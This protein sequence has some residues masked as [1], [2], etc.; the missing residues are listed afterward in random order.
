MRFVEAEACGLG[1]IAVHDTPSSHLHNSHHQ[2]RSPVDL[3]WPTVCPVMSQDPNEK[4]AA[5]ESRKAPRDFW[6]R[7][8]F[9]RVHRPI[10]AQDSTVASTKE[11][12]TGSFLGH[13]WSLIP[14]MSFARASDAQEIRQPLLDLGLSKTDHTFKFQ[15]ELPPSLTIPLWVFVMGYL[16]STFKRAPFTGQ[17]LYRSRPVRQYPSR[18]MPTQQ[19][20]R[21]SATRHFLWNLVAIPSVCIVCAAA[22]MAAFETAEL[23]QELSEDD[24]EEET[25]K[26]TACT[27]DW[28]LHENELGQGKEVEFHHFSTGGH[29]WKMVL[30]LRSGN[31]LGFYVMR[32]G[33]AA[34]MP[35]TIEIASQDSGTVLG[36]ESFK[37]WEGIM[38]DGKGCTI[39]L[40][41]LQDSRILRV[42]VTR[43]GPLSDWRAHLKRLK[44]LSE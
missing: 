36:R 30:K 16:Y 8:G 17:R 6:K 3:S 33:S 40:S 9:S 31:E 13:V 7:W 43:D 4:D 39:P 21:Y 2:K 20:G 28:R 26:T 14:F 1:K 35:F 22:A 34:Q 19:V 25:A 11:S 10:S 32:D 5:A 15:P 23:L 24:D 42:T 29:D 27:L 12:Q 38:I 41:K 44:R 37:H 18:L